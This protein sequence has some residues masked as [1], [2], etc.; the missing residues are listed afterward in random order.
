MMY[1]LGI[2]TV[3]Q[4]YSD[5]QK[6]QQQIGT[7]RRILAPSDDPIASARALEVSQSQSANAQFITNA[8]NATSTLSQQESVLGQVSDVI[9]NVRDLVVT[10]GNS[11]LTDA[12]RTTIANN[13]QGY[14]DQLIGLANSTDSNGQ[15]LF[16][17]YKGS[18]TPFTQSATGVNYNGDQ[19]Q[20]MV[21]ISASR[22][23]AVSS[24]GAEVFQLIKNGNGTFV[25]A[26]AS[27]PVNSG[28]GVVSPGVV[29]DP[30]K[31]AAAPNKDFTV[32][33]NVTAGVTT[34]DVVDNVS[35][36]SLLT[37]AAAAAGPYPRTYTSGTAISLKSQGAEP[38]FDYGAELT[39]SG[40][41]AS[42][43]SFTVKASKTNQDVFSTLQSLITALKAP[44]VGTA[45]T[46]LTNDL[47]TALSNLDHAQDAVLGAR[48]R[49]GLTMNEV[50]AQSTTNSD[51]AVQYAATLSG[52]QDL[53]YNQALSDLSLKQAGLDAAQKSFLKVQGLS[54]FSYIT[55]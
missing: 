52:L 26:T 38:A 2:G 6:L 47:K 25:T 49:A 20:R 27:A 29:L 23:V 43:D 22:Q 4:Q 21:Q 1:E 32:K 15:Y 11:N 14:Y 5:L 41:P 44:V 28:T 8:K 16:S 34:Y 9:Q 53:D 40:Q 42:G 10:A 35:G 37:G 30:A 7:G 45:N 24:S 31:W 19:G 48:S 39:I 36:N 50:D 54:L 3:Q 18:T 17:G 46:Q 13:V 51:M 33:F 55:P 12:Q